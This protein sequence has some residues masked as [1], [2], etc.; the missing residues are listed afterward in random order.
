ML[1]FQLPRRFT[2]I[3]NKKS[4]FISFHAQLSKKTEN[5]FL[6]EA[7]SL[8]AF[9]IVICF[10]C[11]FEL[12]VLMDGNKKTEKKTNLTCHVFQRDVGKPTASPDL[13]VV[14]DRNIA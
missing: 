2:H 6:L 5:N 13:S 11:R 1:A 14:K 3:A 12:F 9:Q 10:C 8:F 4:F 7:D